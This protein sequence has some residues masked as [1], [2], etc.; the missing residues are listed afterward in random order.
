MPP[1]RSTKSKLPVRARLL[2]VATR[3]FAR[4]GF[5]GTTVDEVVAAAKVNKRMVYH[6][7]GDKEGLYHAVLGEAYRSLEA[8]ELDTLAHTR[9]IATLTAEIVRAYFDFLARHPEFVRLLLW[10]NLND[11]RG[12]AQTDARL[13]KDPMLHALAKLLE[14]GIAAGRIRPDMDARHLLISLIGLCLVYSSNRYTLS[15]ALRMDLGSAAV[16]AD[17]IRHVTRLLLD[18]IKVVK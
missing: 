9:D 15:Q 8:V 5:D 13:N 7:F 2:R 3:Q 4:A 6:Y 16:R 11:G 10:E 14:D 18:G 17:G 12:L 1:G